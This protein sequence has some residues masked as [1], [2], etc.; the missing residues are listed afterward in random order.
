MSIALNAPV[1]S[2]GYR[3]LDADAGAFPDRSPT[4]LEAE[5]V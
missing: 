2:P 4:G 1:L 3:D 5:I